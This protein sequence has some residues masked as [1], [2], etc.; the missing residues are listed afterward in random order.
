MLGIDVKT[1]RTVKEQ[2]KQPQQTNTKRYVL[3]TADGNTT[4]AKNRKKTLIDITGSEFPETNFQQQEF[5]F[6]MA[7]DFGEY[8]NEEIL[9]QSELGSDTEYGAPEPGNGR[10]DLLGPQQEQMSS[11][12]VLT[13]ESFDND[14]MEA[15]NQANEQAMEKYGREDEDTYKYD[16]DVNSFYP[17]T[18]GGFVLRS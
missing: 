4:L 7:H 15:I 10:S 9:R 14:D 8:D 5:F 1:S 12:N 18:P 13:Q 6:D 11:F 3:N 17:T 2:L 16:E